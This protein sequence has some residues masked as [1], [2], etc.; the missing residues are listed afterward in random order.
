MKIMSINAGSSSLK[1][2]LFNMETKEVLVSGLFERIGTISACYTIKYNGNKIKEEVELPD[3]KVAVHIL[4]EKLIELNIVSSLDELNGIGHRIVHGGRYYKESTIVTDKVIKD[5]YD[6]ADL[7]P[8]HNKAH[9]LGIEAFKEALPNVPMVVVFDTAFHQ[10]M[11][12]VNYLYPLPLSWASD[13]GVRKYGFHGTSHRYIAKTVAEYLDNKNLK[14]ISCHLGN[15]GSVTAIK[16]GKC[17]DTSMGFTPLAGIMMGTRC[18]DI[19]PSIIPY[20]MEKLGESASEIISDLNKKSGFL[21]LSEYSSDSRD[22]EEK[23]KENDPKAI[24]AQKKFVR[25]V[26]KYISDYYVQLKGADVIAFAGG[27]GENSISTRKAIIEEL[28]CLGIELDDELNNTRGEL[29]L[30]SKEGSTVKVLVVP[31]DE[32]LMIAIDTINLIR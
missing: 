29:K 27:I 20:I 3:H 14:I 12:E 19:D 32:E 5:I 26:V 6:L 30:I 10:T 31:T 8:L 25:T 17:I 15:G 28:A 13:F 7:A 11:E 21:G 23:V 1:F 18:G 4:L 24:L 9:V 2:S 16:D 22:I